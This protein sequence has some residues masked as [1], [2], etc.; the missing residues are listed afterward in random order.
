MN[1]ETHPPYVTV[2]EGMGGWY[3]VLCSWSNEHGGFY[4]PWNTGVGRYPERDG[5]VKE[6]KSW[7]ADEGVDYRD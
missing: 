6:A 7:A 2:G 3:A 1:E 5:A 4:E